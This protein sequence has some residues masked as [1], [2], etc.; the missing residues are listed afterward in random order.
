MFYTYDQFCLEKETDKVC[1][2]IM[3]LNVS[4][5]Q[6]FKTCIGR[7]KH[8]PR[9]EIVKEHVRKYNQTVQ[10]ISSF[11][12]KTKS[13]RRDK[14]TCIYITHHQNRTTFFSDFSKQTFKPRTSNKWVQRSMIPYN[15]WHLT[16]GLNANS[17]TSRRIVFYKLS[18]KSRKIK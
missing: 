7:E 11:F 12:H 14:R 2:C 9:C 8:E 18:T 16:D 17:K 4:N 15:I 13:E 3:L 5:G 6:E 10:S 1:M